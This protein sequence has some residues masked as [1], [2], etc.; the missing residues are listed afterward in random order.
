MINTSELGEISIG[1]KYLSSIENRPKITD[2]IEA[3]RICK[4]LIDAD[5]IGIQEQ[6][7]ILYLNNSNVVI[8]SCN[9]FTGGL[10]GTVVDVKIVVA[11][12]LKLMTSGVIICHNHPSGNTKPSTQDIALTK[13]IKSALEFMDMKLIDHIIITPFDTYTS[14]TQEGLL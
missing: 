9:A 2:T 11:T 5:K 1:Y 7:V 14:F 12:A 3:Y 13:K 10:T 6:F 8:G 4:L